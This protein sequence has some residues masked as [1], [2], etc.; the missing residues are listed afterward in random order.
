MPDE[1]LEDVSVELD[2][3]DDMSAG[4]VTSVGAT[5]DDHGCVS[6]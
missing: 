6:A 2:G 4:V 5:G 3:V 1:E